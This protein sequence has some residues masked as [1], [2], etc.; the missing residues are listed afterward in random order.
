MIICHLGNSC[1]GSESLI[2]FGYQSVNNQLLLRT[3]AFISK[4]GEM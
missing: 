4:K 1:F 2:V 3:I